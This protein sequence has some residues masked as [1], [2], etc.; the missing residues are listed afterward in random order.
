MKKVVKE[1]EEEV[2]EGD[3]GRVVMSWRREIGK[4]EEEKIH[5][6]KSLR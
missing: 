1:E 6:I 3:S 5:C 4:G 2:K